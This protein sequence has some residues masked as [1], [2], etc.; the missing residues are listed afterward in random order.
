M[1]KTHKIW[2]EGQ[3]SRHNDKFI[4]QI[5]GGSKPIEVDASTIRQY[6]CMDKNG[7]NTYVGDE[8]VFSG[9]GDTIEKTII[10]V[11][12]EFHLSPKTNDVFLSLSTINGKGK[13]TLKSKL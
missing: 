8:V 6:V 7:V 11:N 12:G 2:V 9:Y 5:D 4:I 3:L 13:F 1:A 10:Q